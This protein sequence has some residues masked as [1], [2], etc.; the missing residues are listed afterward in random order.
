MDA[1]ET[2]TDALSLLAEML[3]SPNQRI[4]ETARVILR[5]RYT[6]R[7]HPLPREMRG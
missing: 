5:A 6:R 7:R 1:S 3:D 2:P 4:R